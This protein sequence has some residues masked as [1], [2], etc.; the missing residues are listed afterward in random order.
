MRV[1]I[2]RAFVG[3]DKAMG[4][5]VAGIGPPLDPAVLLHAIDLSNQSHRLDFEQIGKAG[6]VD[7]L[8]AG[9]IPQHLAL[10]PGEAEEQ[11]C[12]LVES[13][14]EET[15]DIVNEK[16]EAAVEIHGR[17]QNA[18]ILPDGD[19]KLWYQRDQPF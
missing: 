19:N 3:Q 12:T 16:A 13:T 10:C 2:G 18:K 15:G 1:R 6:L 4:A 11:Q 9:E 7:A 8:V 17:C 5:P 14:P